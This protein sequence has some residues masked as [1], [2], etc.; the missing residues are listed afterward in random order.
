MNHP[1]SC[2]RAIVLVLSAAAATPAQA[3]DYQFHGF[4]AQGFA[5]SDGN[6]AYGSS[7]DGSFDFYELG[8]NGTV[9]FGHGLLASGQGLMRRAGALDRAGARFDYGLLDYR[10]L[11]GGDVDAGVRIGRV[12]N[13]FGLFNETRDVVF[14]RPGI[15]L[16]QSVYFDAA[17]TRTLL[18]SSDGGQLYGGW[19]H[20]DQYL[21]LV[22]SRAL[23]FNLNDDQRRAFTSD[24]N[25]PNDI[26]VSGLSFARL[27]N[28]W[29]GGL[30][31]AG[32]TWTTAQLSIRP[33]QQSPLTADFDI[34]LFVLSLSRNGERYALT[35]EY[36]ATHSRGSS[37]FVPI[38]DTWSDGFYVQ[39]DWR[40]APR[41]RALLRYDASYSDRN[42]RDGSNVA[43]LG[44][45]RHTQFA[46]DITAGIDWRLDPHWGIWAEVH[47]IDGTATVPRGDNVGRI[48]EDRWNLFLLMAAYR[49]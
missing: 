26:H 48:P 3:L 33:N 32:A 15:T 4:A 2:L 18:F 20:G 12:K 8:V 23:D 5:L 29:G 9:D 40:F 17:G 38:N 6:N 47:R 27:M 21:S 16:P 19:Q 28:E 25:I 44:G 30:W 11:R 49:F 34:D 13:P 7:S 22:F 10:F 45:N 43:A 39:G 1:R 14:T 37:N 31:R 42:D 41:W 36:Q 35:A 46:H 24:M